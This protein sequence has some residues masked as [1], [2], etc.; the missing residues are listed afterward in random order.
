MHKTLE[1]LKAGRH[2]T[3]V[4][5]GDSNTE[6]T[7]HTRGRLNWVGLLA[8]ALVETYGHGVCTLV[9]AGKCGSSV[10]E[11]LTRLGADV[12]RFEPDL[13]IVALGLN[14]AG[15]GPAG[16]SAFRDGLRQLVAG[17]RG[18]GAEVLLRTPNPVVTVHG[19]PLPPEQPK[20]GRPWE[21][22]SR[23]LALYARAIVDA[24]A[25]L[26]CPVVDHYS[27]WCSRKFHPRQPVLDPTGLWPRMGDAVHPGPLGHLAFFRELADRFEVPRYFAW[28]DVSPGDGDKCSM[29][30][31]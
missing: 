20:P 23:P 6:P 1:K 8:E 28:E 10:A 15:Q 14:D 12:L 31:A 13:V 3:I 2:V 29:Y 5:L 11:S 4:A 16:L 17:I 9:N 18:A 22:P 30:N 25:E 27:L 24:A 19:L 26:H 21:S 7:F